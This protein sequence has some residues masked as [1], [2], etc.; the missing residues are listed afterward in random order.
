MVDIQNGQLSRQMVP[1]QHVLSI[2]QDVELQASQTRIA[3]GEHR[4]PVSGGALLGNAMPKAMT[5]L[6]VV[7]VA[8]PKLCLFS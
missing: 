1:V 7:L 2:R 4:H 6:L 8:S 3:I 5:D